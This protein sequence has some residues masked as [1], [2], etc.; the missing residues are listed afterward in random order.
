M[1]A[2]V[3]AP[4]FGDHVV[5]PNAAELATLQQYDTALGNVGH[6]QKHKFPASSFPWFM[7]IAAAVNDATVPSVVNKVPHPI[8]VWGVDAAVESAAG[9][10]CTIDLHADPDGGTTFG[11][12]LAAAIDVKTTAGTAVRAAPNDDECDLDYGAAVKIVAVGTGA[13][14]V[15]GAQAQLWCQRR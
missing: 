7:F 13:G 3:N 4:F 6:D 14:A 12:I 2:L 8:R 1:T 10:A 11:S 9:S 15:V 5:A